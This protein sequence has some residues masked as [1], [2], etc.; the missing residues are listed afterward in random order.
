VAPPEGTTWITDS[1]LLHENAQRVSS[2][3]LD[4]PDPTLDTLL[5]PSCSFQHSG[6]LSE[7]IT[8][9][10]SELVSESRRCSFVECQYRAYLIALEKKVFFL[11]LT[12]CI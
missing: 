4:T 11:L 12:T 3:L 8:S 7:N 5:F 10:H 9:R 6:R 1:P 2:S